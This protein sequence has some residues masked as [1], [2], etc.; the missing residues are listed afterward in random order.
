MFSRYSGSNLLDFF[1]L[2]ISFLQM[3][4]TN[5]TQSSAA[6]SV[7]V[8]KVTVNVKGLVIK[9]IFFFYKKVCFQR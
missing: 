3:F 5:A 9:F 6:G 8:I 2:V 4:M 7:K 1:I